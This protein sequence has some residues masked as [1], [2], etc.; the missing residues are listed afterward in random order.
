MAGLSKTQLLEI[1]DKANPGSRIIKANLHTAIGRAIV[2][3]NHQ[4]AQ[5]ISVRNQQ[6]IK[7]QV[8]QHVQIH[9]R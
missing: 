3:N 2:Q 7:R 4:V 6:R 9:H 8:Q 1:L 5:S